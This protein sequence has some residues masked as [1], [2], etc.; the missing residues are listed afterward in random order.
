MARILTGMFLMFRL[1][2]Q[3]LDV[4]WALVT[5]LMYARPVVEVIVERPSEERRQLIERLDAMYPF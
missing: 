1:A 5:R 2:S 4:D 3:R